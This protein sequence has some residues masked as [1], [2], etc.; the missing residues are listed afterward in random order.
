MA[1]MASLGSTNNFSSLVPSVVK[2]YTVAS[3]VPMIKFLFA[4]ERPDTISVCR[5]RGTP[6]ILLLIAH[7]TPLSSVI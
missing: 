6:A 5:E 7:E 2:W 4:R 3:D 1:Q